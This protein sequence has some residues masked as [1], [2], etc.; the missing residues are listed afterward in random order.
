LK[1]SKYPQV[2]TFCKT[3]EKPDKEGLLKLQISFFKL[4]V[5]HKFVTIGHTVSKSKKKELAKTRLLKLSKTSRIV[6]AFSRHN[7]VLGHSINIFSLFLIIVN[8]YS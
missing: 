4:L 5:S 8:I 7:A 6:T 2:P 1:Y 3:L